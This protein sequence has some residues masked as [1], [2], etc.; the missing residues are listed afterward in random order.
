MHFSRCFTS[1]GTSALLGKARS[2]FAHLGLFA[3]LL[4]LSA[5][6]SIPAHALQVAPSTTT[7]SASGAAPNYTLN[8]TVSATAVPTGSVSFNDTSNGGQLLGTAALGNPSTISLGIGGGLS[9]PANPESS[10]IA[11]GDFNGDGY[12]DI[13]IGPGFAPNWPVCKLQVYFSDG[14]DGFSSAS[15]TELACST[16]MVAADFN[17]DGKSE[18]ALVQNQDIAPGDYKSSLVILGADLAP[19]KT[20]FLGEGSYTWGGIAAGDLDGD[21]KADLIVSSRYGTS[22]LLNDAGAWQNVGSVPLGY[23]FL[24]IADV[25]GDGKA[26]LIFLGALADSVTVYPGNGNG[27]FGSPVTTAVPHF[28]GYGN[29]QMATGDFNADGRADVAFEGRIEDSDGAHCHDSFFVLFGNLDGSFDVGSTTSF[30]SCSNAGSVATADF[31]A[32]GKSDIA[33]LTDDSVRIL[34]SNGTGIFTEAANIDS[35][36]ESGPDWLALGTGD[37]NAD[38]APDFAIVDS[39]A[40]TATVHFLRRTMRASAVLENVVVPGGGIH[41]VAATYEGDSHSASSVSD[42]IGLTGTPIPTSLVLRASPVNTSYGSQVALTAT[43][44]PYILGGL[45]T[46]GE[47]VAFFSNATSIGTATLSAGSA[48]FNIGSLPVGTN[49]ITASYQADTNFTSSASSAVTVKVNLA[50]SATSLKVSPTTSTFGSQTT[51]TTTVT[52][53]SGLAA[54]TGVVT[55]LNGTSSIGSANLSDGIAIL[56]TAELPIGTDSLSAAYQGSNIFASSTSEPVQ[57]TITDPANPTPTVS[58]STPA[59]THAGNGAFEL[60]VDGTGFISASVINWGTTALPTTYVS[61]TQLEATVP[62]AFVASEG[63]VSITVVNRPGE[64]V[65]NAFTFHVDSA[66]A[67]AGVPAFPNPTASVSAGSPA[68]YSVSM[69]SSVTSATVNCLNLPA[70]TAC[71]YSASQ[72]TLTITTGASTPKGTYQVTTVFTESISTKSAAYV[73]L[74]FLL[75]PLYKMR[76]NLRASPHMCLALVSILAVTTLFTLTGCGGGARATG[77]QPSQPSQQQVTSSAVV[78][79]T[80]K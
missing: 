9:L 63:A 16:N 36:A 68:T 11:I 47:Q 65:S 1:L 27:T 41:Q 74:P 62:A 77:S 71:T 12:P 59:Y 21:G 6:L 2:S 64:G 5:F 43:L 46:T 53:R 38:G 18:I 30:G 39:D 49:E 4:A 31:N 28:Y 19:T 50:P 58:G 67:P 42:P 55:F 60:T 20:V 22:I 13:A 37:F 7:I 80:I 78:T 33:V 75:I 51:L 8:G 25:T 69:P 73:L 17:G 14:K 24:R 45:S 72:G 23:N 52:G 26:D 70:G 54:P 34:L 79:L 29:Q 32:D 10:D 48:T 66:S 56:E 57:V 76:K 40:H 44:S 3:A 61:A 35:G 15:S